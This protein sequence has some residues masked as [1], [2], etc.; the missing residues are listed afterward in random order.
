VNTLAATFSVLFGL[1]FGSFLNVCISRLPH[2]ESVVTPR[3][4]C[5]HCRTPIRTWDNVPL[6]AWLLLRGRCRACDTPIPFRYFLVEAVTAALFL[7][8]FLTFGLSTRGVASA[9]L[10]FLLVGIAAMDAE[11]LLLPDA[12]TL[13]GIAL[14]VFYSG[15][16]V[17]ALWTG[18]FWPV[19]WHGHARVSTA[20]V[21]AL[22][23]GAAAAVVLVIRWLYWLVRRQEG[24][25]LGDAKLF[26]MIGAWL[27][28]AQTFLV[29][30]LAVITG[31]LYGLALILIFRGRR[32][33]SLGQ[34][35]AATPTQVPLGSFLCLAAIYSL[36]WG[37]QTIAWYHHLFRL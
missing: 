33:R 22:A 5:P 26:A 16:S 21:A 9:V 19:I 14:G 12:F 23:A 3:S 30:F 11:T 37:E 24:M 10:C 2:G 1:A 31:A 25:G 32:S 28:P 36:F 18:L 6:I 15:V 27:G 7:L 34:I 29:F 13:P 8:C 20:I 4:R 35:A 17:G